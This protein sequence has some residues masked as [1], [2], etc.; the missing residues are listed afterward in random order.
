MNEN[1]RNATRF[2]WRIRKCPS[3]ELEFRDWEA[4][5]E[6]ARK[7][8]HL[9]AESCTARHVQTGT[10]C[11]KQSGHEGQHA[12]LGSRKAIYWGAK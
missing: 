8:L 7:T 9:E 3:C 1:W 4:Q 10:Q 12:Y 2:E 6:H 11:E 5:Y